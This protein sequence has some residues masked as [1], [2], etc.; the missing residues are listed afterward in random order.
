MKDFSF[1]SLEFTK[2]SYLQ[3]AYQNIVCRR[4]A[5]FSPRTADQNKQDKSRNQIFSY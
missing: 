1:F 3:N 4:L 2:L 5:R